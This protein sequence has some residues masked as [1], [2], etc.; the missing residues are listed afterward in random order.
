MAVVTPVVSSES[1]GGSSRRLLAIFVGLLAFGFVAGL[2]SPAYAVLP[3]SNFQGNDGNQTDQGSFI[4]WQSLAAVGRVTTIDDP[5]AADTSFSGGDKEEAPIDWNLG[6]ET[7]GVNPPKDNIFTAWASLDQTGSATFLYL[8]F[9]REE[10]G[11]N[12]NTF[13]TF[14]LNQSSATWVNAEG[15]TIPCRTAGDLAV[16]YNVGGNLAVSFTVYEWVPA[17]PTNPD[18]G[19]PE[20]QTGTWQPLNVGSNAE[21]AMNVDGPIANFLSTSSPF[22]GEF[23][24]GTFGEAAVN[25]TALLSGAGVSPCVH[26]VQ[27]QVHSRSS[28]EINSQLQDLLGPT[29]FTAQTCTGTGTKFNDLNGN[30]ARELGEPGLAGWTFFVDYNGNGTVDPGEPTAV[31]D[32]SGNFTFSGV[33]PGAWTVRE[34]AQ[35]GW[36]CTFPTPNCSYVRTFTAGTTSGL[37]FGNRTTPPSPPPPPPPTAAPPGAA[38]PPQQSPPAQVVPGSSNA[39]GPSRCVQSTFAVRVTGRNIA[40]VVFFIDGKR[41]KTVTQPDR[42]GRFVLRVDTTR[43]NRKPHKLRAQV[44]YTDAS[45]TASTT[46]KLTFK[47]CAKA[48]VKPRFTG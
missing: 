18:L 31:S 37:L 43:Y 26:F 29:A 21:G 40:R 2:G 3:G 13:L 42:L 14:E 28:I 7:D 11:T 44:F 8:A 10:T 4:D 1:S 5:N 6:T 39:V 27:I 48:K 23:P 24:Q 17:P 15:D 20:G 36:T 47:R 16:S 35:P 41:V 22:D 25:L 9:V 30:G 33:N 32:A 34:V 45:H 38:P 12:G 19:C 46:K